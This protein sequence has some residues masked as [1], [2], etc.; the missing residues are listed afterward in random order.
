MTPTLAKQAAKATC[1]MLREEACPH[2]GLAP[3]REKSLV[4]IANVSK[5]LL[6]QNFISRNL[7]ENLSVADLCPDEIC[8]NKTEV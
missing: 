1:K 7:W 3:P 5:T 8:E 6:S 4:R 2:R